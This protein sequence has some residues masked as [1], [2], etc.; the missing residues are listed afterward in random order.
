MSKEKEPDASCNNCK[1]L[2]Y[3]NRYGCHVR[4]EMAMQEDKSPCLIWDDGSS[5]WEIASVNIK[6]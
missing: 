2:L 4:S 1:Y 5:P 3:P 6:G